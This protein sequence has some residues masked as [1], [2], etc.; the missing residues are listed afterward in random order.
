M[1]GLLLGVPIAE[2]AQARPYHGV[3]LQP[4]GE[5]IEGFIAVAGNADHD[6]VL[7]ID[8]TFKSGYPEP[9]MMAPEVVK[10]VTSRWDQ[11]VTA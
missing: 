7:G 4:R 9:V 10:Q 11:Y 6:R 3:D 5:C 2:D 8:A 1:N